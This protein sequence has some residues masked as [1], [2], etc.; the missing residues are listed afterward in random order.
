MTELVNKTFYDGNVLSASD[1]NEITSD[2]SKNRTVS[3]ILA[4]ENAGFTIPELP[5]SESVSSTTSPLKVYSSVLLPNRDQGDG[6]GTFMYWRIL[7][8]QYQTNP[9]DSLNNL[10]WFF[11]KVGPPKFGEGLAMGIALKISYKWYLFYYDL[12]TSTAKIYDVDTS[13][14]LASASIS[15]PSSFENW[16]VAY[17][18]DKTSTYTMSLYTDQ[19]SLTA[20]TGVPTGTI[21]KIRILDEPNIPYNH[22]PTRLRAPVIFVAQYV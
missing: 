5:D 22:D 16:T 21:Q 3:T 11:S 10:G 20:T 6:N 9:F 19:V 13:T 18:K 7:D 4:L 15:S 1:L 12:S 14:T 8:T 17:F 2:I